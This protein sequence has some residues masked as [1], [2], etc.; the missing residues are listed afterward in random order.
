MT[1]SVFESWSVD[2]RPGTRIRGRLVEHVGH[3]GLRDG[4]N[5]PG[6][7]SGRTAT[8]GRVE[9]ARAARLAE[10]FADVVSKVTPAV[11]TIRTERAASPQMTQ[12]PQMP[13]GFPFGEFFGQ[14][15]AR[16]ARRP[17][18]AGADAARARVGC[19]RQH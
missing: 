17:A 1:R 14:G 18:D 15:T 10:G 9:G 7:S 4:R 8:A 6:D 12:L 3:I 13:E 11:V 2:L 19:H 5:G 16:A